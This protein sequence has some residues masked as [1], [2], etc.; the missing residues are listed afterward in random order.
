MATFDDEEKA[1]EQK[2]TRF[3]PRKKFLFFKVRSKPVYGNPNV[4]AKQIIQ[5]PTEEKGSKRGSF[6]NYIDKT[7]TKKKNLEAALRD[8]NIKKSPHDFVKSAIIYTILITV[9]V[10]AALGIVLYE[11]ILDI[12][13]AAVL[14][15]TLGFAVY[16]VMFNNFLNYP[17]TKSKQV[18]KQIDR[19]ILFASRDIVISMRS[20]MPLF[21]A[22]T[23]VSTGYGAASREFAKI[24]DLIELNVPI[25][26]AIEEVSSKSQSN[27]F[28]RVMLQASVSVK[29]GVDVTQALQDVVEEITQERVIELRRYGQKLNA[30][31]MFYM[32][33]GI[34]FPS[35]GIAVAAI[36]TTFIS[37][38]TIDAT[39]LVFGLVGIAMLQII[40]INMIKGSRPV[41]AM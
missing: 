11:L 24:I 30:L 38:F 16:T 26:Q 13:I 19:D 27:T 40:F 33:F 18:G 25:E 39:T 6:S 3:T 23:A 36:L 41:F 5:K 28:R 2:P 20:G 35:M 10:V 1:A 32:L 15:G 17:F 21:N 7:A 31:A 9:A 22:M 14:A 29:A 34:I 4:I 8:L 12:A 37:I